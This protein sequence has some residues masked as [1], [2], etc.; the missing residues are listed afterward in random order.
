MASLTGLSAVFIVTEPSVS[1]IHDF[2]RIAD[3]VNQFKIRGFVCVNKYDLNEEKTSE[4]VRMSRQKGFDFIGKIPFD[5]TVVKA[6]I[7]G[8]TV[9]EYEEGPAAKEMRVVWEC[10]CQKMSLA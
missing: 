5:P 10:L 6:L 8:K 3:L 9:L 2:E 4:I 7:Q 1:G